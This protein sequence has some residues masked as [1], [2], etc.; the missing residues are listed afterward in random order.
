VAG[1]R[2]LARLAVFRGLQHQVA[3]IP[4][5][6]APVLALPAE[7]LR[8]VE[9][10]GG[11]WHDTRRRWDRV[12]VDLRDILAANLSSTNSSAAEGMAGQTSPIRG[13]QGIKRCHCDLLTGEFTVRRLGAPLLSI[14][15]I[16]LANLRG[17][18]LCRQASIQYQ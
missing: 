17:G 6:I 18:P 15:G 4:G 8:D 3:E 7:E 5:P 12:R 16:G 13:R 11:R 9:H 2:F 10:F 1:G 14:R